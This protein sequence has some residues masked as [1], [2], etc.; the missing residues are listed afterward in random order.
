MVGLTVPKKRSNT[1]RW[2]AVCDPPTGRYTGCMATAKLPLKLK[3]CSV[4]ASNSVGIGGARP[5]DPSGERRRG[6]ERPQAQGI[7]SLTCVL[8]KSI[9]SFVGVA[10]PVHGTPLFSLVL[11]SLLCPSSTRGC[12]RAWQFPL[13]FLVSESAHPRHVLC[14][15]PHCLV[16]QSWHWTALILN[17]ERF[18]ECV[19]LGGLRQLAVARTSRPHRDYVSAQGKVFPHFGVAP[20]VGVKDSH[21]SVW[22]L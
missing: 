12:L 19:L 1:T 4:G 3:R 5:R 10:F 9:S 11:Q 6:G 8:M 15:L 20:R 22:P 13:H 18:L 7:C 17:S 21:S 14:P 16:G 2:C